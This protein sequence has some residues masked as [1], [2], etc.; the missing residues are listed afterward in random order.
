MSYE[1]VLTALEDSASEKMRRFVPYYSGPDSPHFQMLF[2]GFIGEGCSTES[3]GGK[4]VA[5]LMENCSYEGVQTVALPDPL[6]SI[7]LNPDYVVIYTFIPRSVRRTD[8]QL[9]WLVRDSAVEG[10]DFNVGSVAAVWEPTL[11]EDKTLAENTQLGID[12]TAYRPGPYMETENLVSD[13]DHWYSE[14]VDQ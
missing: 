5:P 7:Y 2:R 6:T 10:V 14:R 9:M 1:A 3:V 13:F 12:S 11:R 8:M 4:P